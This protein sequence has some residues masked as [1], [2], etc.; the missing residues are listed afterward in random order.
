MTERADRVFSKV[1]VEESPF[2]VSVLYRTENSG[3]GVILSTVA[4]RPSRAA[5]TV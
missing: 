1:A 4:K 2:D 3:L 5:R